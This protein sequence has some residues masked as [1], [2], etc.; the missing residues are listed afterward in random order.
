MDILDMDNDTLW[1]V[2][3]ELRSFKDA[4]QNSSDPRPIRLSILDMGGPAWGDCSTEEVLKFL[5]LLRHLVRS[6]NITALVTMS[7]H[8]SIRGELSSPSDGL[9]DKIGFFSDAC[10]SFTGFGADPSL[11][12]LF[13]TYHGAVHLI[14]PPS[15]HTLL[16][17]S[18]RHSV[19]RGSSNG[20]ENNLA[21]KCTRKRFMIE[22]LHLDVEG[23]VSER[24]TT[25]GP[26]AIRMAHTDNSPYDHH[27]R[28]LSGTSSSGA[29]AA[30]NI[31]LDEDVRDN[32]AGSDAPRAS[33]GE[34]DET[35][36]NLPKGS[37]FTTRFREGKPKKRVAFHTDRPDIYDF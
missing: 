36:S 27:P 17:F 23:G 29:N 16:P 22:T 12:S 5:Y 37:P 32:N 11:S 18:H 25:P 2:L 30:I 21:F 4:S 3:S 6:T 15:L 33:T 20:G 8:L 28:V 13:Q 10:I 14:R 35:T 19:L 31:A 34:G 1:K 9:L 7:S 26:S 24:R